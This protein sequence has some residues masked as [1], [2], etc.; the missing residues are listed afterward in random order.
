MTTMSAIETDLD[1]DGGLRSEAYDGTPPARI[2]GTPHPTRID[3]TPLKS[4]IDGKNES[5]RTREREQ[6]NGR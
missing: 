3:G 5:R 2:G 4:T 1:D 6:T